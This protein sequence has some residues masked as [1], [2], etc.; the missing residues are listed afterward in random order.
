MSAYPKTTM[1]TIDRVKLRGSI[2]RYASDADFDLNGQRVDA[3]TANFIGRPGD[4]ALGKTV[5]VDGASAA[6]VL[7]AS[8]VRL[9]ERPAQGNLTLQGAI[10][11]LDTTALTFVLRGSVVEYGRRMRGVL[12]HG[13]AARDEV[14]R[15]YDWD[16]KGEPTGFIF[17]PNQIF[18][19]K[20][21]LKTPD[22]Y[23]LNQSTI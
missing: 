23:F 14:L 2:T 1:E 20:W 13:R 17:T 12:D 21:P 5:V 22:I 9:E 3:R 15:R 4:L 18:Q 8:R 10:E 11:S 7:I 6:G 16:R 19:A